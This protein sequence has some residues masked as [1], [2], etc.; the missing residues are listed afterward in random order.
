VTLLDAPVLGSL[1]EAEAG[2]LTLFVGGPTDVITRVRP[3]LSTLGDPVHVGPAG[4]GA[5]AKLV[6]NLALLGTVGILGE[7]LAFADSLG[8]PRAVTWRVLAHTPLAD[9]AGRRRPVVESGVF[10]PRF[11]LSLARKDADLIV[12]AADVTETDVRLTAAARTWLVDAEAAGLGGGDYTAVLHH[13]PSSRRAEIS[14]E[15]GEPVTTATA[16][17]YTW[18]SGCD[19]WRL[20]DTTG[21]SAT[22]ERM[23]PHTAETWHTHDYA[24]QFFYIL[25]GQ[26]TMRTPAGEVVLPTGSGMRIAPG[27]PH[28]MAN[29]YDEDLRFLVVGAPSTRG[30]RRNRHQA[31]RP[32]RSLVKDEEG[33]R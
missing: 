4:S 14:A 16:P 9:Q 15:I 1:A 18:G 13:I 26:A 5:A 33:D 22:E 19:G 32:N 31:V 2:S 21:F 27:T 28:Q 3:L 11:A 25:D 20:V 12:A 23:P 29:T 10:P 24:Q 7:A 30:D 17:H 8:L 6:A